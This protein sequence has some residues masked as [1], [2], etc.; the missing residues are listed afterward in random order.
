M[1]DIHPSTR[2]SEKTSHSKKKIDFVSSKCEVSHFRKDGVVPIEQWLYQMEYDLKFRHVPRDLFV[3]SII[4]QVHSKHFKEVRAHRKL[5]YKAFR[6]TLIKLYKRPDLTHVGIQ[7]LLNISQA[8]DEALEDFA[9]RVKELVDLGYPKMAD[10]EKNHTCIAAFSR[11]LFERQIAQHV[12][13]AGVKTLPEAVRIDGAA[14]IF[15]K[16]P[17]VIR[18]K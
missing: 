13:V 5:E 1:D 17:V 12:S 7:E 15:S 4:N 18:S 11:G 14:G 8:R 6:K 16:N 3:Q 2:H 10:S 9:D